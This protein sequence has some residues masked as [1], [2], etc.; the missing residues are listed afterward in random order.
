M[1]SE[2]DKQKIMELA[3]KYKIKRVLL[4]GSSLAS[5]KDAN[6]IDLAVDGLDVS[7]F[8]TFYGELIFSLSKPV[9]LI[10]ISQDSLIKKSVIQKS[11]CLYE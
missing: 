6:D 2:I 3:E 9:D 5:P 11:I 10:D 4:F 1:I 8:F 7:L